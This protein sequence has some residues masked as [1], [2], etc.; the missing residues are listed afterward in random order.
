MEFS[1]NINNEALILIKHVCLLLI[2]QII[3]SIEIITH[4][5]P[6]HDAFTRDFKRKKQ[7]ELKK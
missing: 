4:N 2:K 1:A 7:Y 3:N 6:I 5:R